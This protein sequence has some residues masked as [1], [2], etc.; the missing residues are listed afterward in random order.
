MALW[1]GQK[2][3]IFGINGNFRLMNI[4]QI[5]ESLQLC[6]VFFIIL[7]YFIHSVETNINRICDSWVICLTHSFQF[8]LEKSSRPQHGGH[9][10]EFMLTSELELPSQIMPVKYYNGDDVSG[11]ITSKPVWYSALWI[12]SAR[13]HNWKEIEY[14]YQTS[15]TPVSLVCA[16]ACSL[17][18]WWSH[19][20]QKFQTI[21]TLSVF[22]SLAPVRF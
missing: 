9:F 21:I 19:Q 20:L 13:F 10:E 5:L 18:C 1:H 14:H 16:Y 4:C 3:F 15:H 11:D 22:N 17:L 8:Q 7:F 12:E 6:Q 2:P